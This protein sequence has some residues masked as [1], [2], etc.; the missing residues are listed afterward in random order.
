MSY[1]EIF[2]PGYDLYRK[3]RRA[4]YGGVLLAVRNNL[5]SHQ[6]T[7]DTEAEYIAA[8]IISGKTTTIVGAMYRPTNN[9]QHYMDCLNKAIIETCQKNP[10]A[11]IWLG[12]DTNHPDID[13]ESNQVVRH[14]YPRA[15]NELFLQAI[16]DAGLEQLVNFPTRGD[17]TLDVILTNRPT[18]TIRC[19]GLP[20]LSDHDLVFTEV[21]I[22]AHR[23]KP[24]R[25]KISLWKKADWDT[26]KERVKK[27]SSEFTAQNSVDT[28]VE[29]LADDLQ[30]ELEKVLS[31]HV[32]SKFS[33]TRL[34][35][36]W[37]NAKTKR[38]VR[39]KKRAYKR[40]RH[41]GKERDWARFN[42]LKKETKKICRQAYNK[43]VFDVVNSDPCG[44]KKL[45]ALVKSKR[46]D[47]LGV[48]PLKEAGIVHTDPKHKANVLNKQFTSVFSSVDDSPLP[49]LGPSPHPSVS[50]INISCNGV[51]K[52][53]KN[54]KP[55]KATGPDG[56]PAQLLRETAEEIS[57]ALT[58][59]FQA[60][61]D[62]GAVPS[63]WKK[64]NVVPIFKKAVQQQ[65]ITVQSRSHRYYASYWSTLFIAL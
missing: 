32:P 36:P 51:T 53:L 16:A 60:S 61:L 65:Q 55:H 19:E 20:A 21:N 17:R 45:G 18:L 44:N 54:L 10:G 31:D 15:L 12:G 1:G 28:P 2:P 25:H 46:C 59:L 41:T 62:Q 43:H 24:I 23:R 22:Q 27:W 42:W 4:G 40:A 29:Q 5:N 8:K 49:D 6:L 50:N 57:P 9:D 26:I 37:F 3:D 35:Q 38:A 14:Q 11:F 48:S 39:R 52:L 47:Q 64:A 34:G 33:S 63:S 58:L 56:I 13:W 30:Q 7:I